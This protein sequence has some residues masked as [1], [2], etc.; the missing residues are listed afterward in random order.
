MTTQPRWRGAATFLAFVGLAVAARTCLAEPFTVPSGSMEPTLLVGDYIVTSKWAYGLSRYSPPVDLGVPGR[1]FGRAPERGDVV[2]FRPPL[3][4]AETWVKRVIGLPGD[5][6]QVVGGVLRINGETVRRERIEDRMIRSD[7]GVTIVAQYVETLPN[8]V[9]HVIALSGGDTGRAENTAEYV[10]PPGHY[11]MM[12]D[13]RDN[14]LDSRFPDLGFVPEDNLVSRVEAVAA[15]LDKEA[16]RP[17][18]D[19]LF[20]KVS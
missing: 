20:A 6:V 11:F 2:V 10:V 5:R 16:W 3:R 17:R 7:S 12:G 18:L 4:P 8:G 13:N 15:S 14:S 19:R 1:L 9:R